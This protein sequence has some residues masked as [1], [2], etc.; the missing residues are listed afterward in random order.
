MALVLSEIVTEVDDII[1]DA[2]LTTAMV[3]RQ[4]GI[5]KREIHQR[6]NQQFLKK[7]GTFDSV[8]SQADY[9]LS[10]SGSN[11]TDLDGQKVI[12]IRPPTTTFREI[13]YL[14]YDQFYQK[15]ANWVDQFGDPIYWTWEDYQIIRVNPIPNAIATYTI[16]YQKTMTEITD[17]SDD[18]TELDIP[19]KYRN[20]LVDGALW[21]CARIV[22]EEREVRFKQDYEEAKARMLHDLAPSKGSVK[23]DIRLGLGIYW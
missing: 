2:K 21:R 19:D 18:N 3:Q 8:A 16:Y 9:D 14:P 10:A 7:E 22:D 11:L 13:Q 4:V 12:R 15:I 1:T 23:P 5:V 6:T 20:V 17:D